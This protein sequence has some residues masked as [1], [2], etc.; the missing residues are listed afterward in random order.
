MENNKENL[1]FIKGNTFIVWGSK[2]NEEINVNLFFNQ[3]TH[4]VPE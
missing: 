3:A 2:F 4:Y 1:D